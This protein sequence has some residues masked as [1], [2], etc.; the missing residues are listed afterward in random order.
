MNLRRSRDVLLSV[1]LLTAG[2]GE[3]VG[4]GSVPPAPAP[5]T[6]VG[7]A[8]RGGELA[9]APPDTVDVALVE[10]TIGMPSRLSAGARVWR[11]S[12]QG[13]EGHNLRIFRAE[14]DSLVWETDADV[15]PGRT[16]YA[17]IEL[18]SGAYTVLCDVAGHDTRG[19]ITQIEV[20]E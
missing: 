15:D 8:E 17:T 19:M 11:L 12:N 16:D 13:F 3:R 9:A 6:S 7:S 4:S 5:T 18:A 10:Y 1:A 20:N 14:T 2:C